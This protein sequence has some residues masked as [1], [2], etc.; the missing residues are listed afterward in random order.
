MEI[1]GKSAYHINSTSGSQNIGNIIGTKSTIQQSKFFRMYESGNAMK[2]I[3]GNVTL[4]W[5]VNKKQ[6]AYSGKVFD[7]NNQ[8]SSQL[9]NK[10]NSK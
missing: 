10:I 1:P 2:S 5:D 9:S 7:D 4:S 3:L 8:L 6:G